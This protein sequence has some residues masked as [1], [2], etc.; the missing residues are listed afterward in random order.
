MNERGKVLDVSGGKDRENQNIIV[1]NRHNRMN[2]RWVI[3]YADKDE[4]EP[5]KGELN[6]EFGLY[7]ERSFYVI[8]GLS[9]GRYLDLRGRSLVIRK[10]RGQTS[11]Q[12]YFDQR[13]KTIKSVSRS[14]ESWDIANAGRSSNL[15][16]WRT[17]SGW[18]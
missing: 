1:W 12:W 16:V 7:V 9:S 17:N 10:F 4:P 5:K 14:N 18:W 6:K 13:T 3:V 11:C 8:S 2:Q 15:Q